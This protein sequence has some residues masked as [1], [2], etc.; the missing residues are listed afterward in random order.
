[1]NV[2]LHLQGWYPHPSRGRSALCMLPASPSGA[3]GARSGSSNCHLSSVWA[4]ATSCS[5]L[6]GA[7]AVLDLDV[8]AHLLDSRLAQ[9]WRCHSRVLQS[10]WAGLCSGT[11]LGTCTP[12][13]YPKSS[14]DVS[15]WSYVGQT[16]KTLDCQCLT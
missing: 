2:S 11:L 1:M 5:M 4:L 6:E 7:A 13:I 10:C 9:T 15:P 14:D 12:C 3:A 8:L 16:M